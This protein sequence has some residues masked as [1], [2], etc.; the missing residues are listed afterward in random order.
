MP[1]QPSP[2][3]TPSVVVSQYRA[4]ALTQKIVE[5]QGGTILNMQLIPTGETTVL[6]TVYS[7]DGKI[8]LHLSYLDETNQGS[9]DYAIEDTDADTLEHTD[10]VAAIVKVSKDGGKLVPVVAYNYENLVSGNFQVKIRD[11]QSKTVNTIPGVKCDDNAV[12]TVSQDGSTLL[13]SDNRESMWIYRINKTTGLHDRVTVA[14]AGEKIIRYS[15][16]NNS[17]CTLV[18]IAGEKNLLIYALKSN[19]WPSPCSQ[20]STVP[21]STQSANRY[22]QFLENG[23]SVLVVSTTGNNAI[24]AQLI[25]IN[26]QTGKTQADRQP[27]E[28]TA[29]ISQES[30]PSKWGSSTVCIFPV[31]AQPP[32]TVIAIV[33]IK[34][35]SATEYFDLHKDQSSGKIS[36]S[37]SGETQSIQSIKLDRFVWGQKSLDSSTTVP[38]VLLGV[39]SNNIVCRVDCPI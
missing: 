38:S 8:R 27:L 17:S 26:P 15:T 28:T 5:G 6:G 33:C 11:L 22:I 20:D 35:D 21:L 9:S 3:P 24:L 23:S 10:G 1:V 30:T 12:I 13:V 31:S 36:L 2:Q 39:V 4:K 34:G 18:G 19:G 14:K 29:S 25:D 16:L 7:K 32:S 37:N